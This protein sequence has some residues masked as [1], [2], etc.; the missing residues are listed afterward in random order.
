MQSIPLPRRVEREIDAELRFHLESRVEDLIAAGH[1]AE[2]ARQIAAAEYGNIDASRRELAE[3]DRRI[4]ARSR[5][6]DR[7]DGIRHDI[8]YAARSLWRQPGFTIGVGLTLAIA[9]GANAAVFTLIDPLLFRP[10][11]GVHDPS[12]VVRLYVNSPNSPRAVNGRAI[13]PYVSY[14]EFEAIR[15][16]SKGLA[17]IAAHRQFDSSLVNRG[18]DSAFVNVSYVTADFLSILGVRATRGRFFIAIE[19]DVDVPANVCVVSEA[20]AHRMFIDVERA[21][22]QP[23]LVR[24]KPCTVIGVAGGGFRGISTSATD[25]WAPFSGQPRFGVGKV[26][27]YRTADT[28][29]P[30]IARLEPGAD[31]L[32][33]AT[34]ASVGLVRAASQPRSSDEGRSVVLG[35]LIEGRGPLATPQV[36]AIGTRLAVVVA[37]ILVIA[38]ANVGNLYL[39]RAIRRRR[40]T[41]MRLAL[42]ISRGRL[43]RQS[44]IEG[45]LLA[46][47]CGLAA[48]FVAAWGGGVLRT[49]LLPRIHWIGAPLDTR[50][51]AFSVVT[52]LLA[53]LLAAIVPATV[54]NQ[55]LI[56]ESLKLGL[57][58]A[59]ADGSRV[60]ATLLAIQAALSLVLVVG[61]ALFVQS[62]RNVQAIDFGIDTDHVVS[63]SVFFLDGKAHREVETLIP[64]VVQNLPTMAGVRGV[65][66]ATG[67]PLVAWSSGVPLFESGRASEITSE[68]HRTDFIGVAAGY[69]EVVGTP[70]VA[71][72]TFLASDRRDAPPVAVVSNSLAKTLWPNE[73]AIGKCLIP[74]ERRNPCYTIVGV[75]RDVHEFRLMETPELHFYLPIDQVP[76]GHAPLAIFVNADAG[77]LDAVT[78]SLTQTLTGTFPGGQVR[79]R[80][81]AT[82]LAPQLRPWRLGAQL[83]GALG[84][85]SLLVASVGVYSVV[86]FTVQQR[87]HEIG[88]R[89]TLGATAGDIIRHVVG[90][91][92][93]V[94]AV[95]VVVGVAVT[96][97]GGRFIASLLYGISPRDVPAIAVSASA[98]LLV[99]AV[100]SLAPACRAMR[101]DPATILR[102]E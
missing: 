57:R 73:S 62:L 69:F 45:F 96:L 75:A 38:C 79:V 54:A 92:S 41:A 80:S 91:S 93:L 50:V 85:L 78:M 99:G 67:G 14:P 76:R 71:G 31:A 23:L 21:I 10:P 28:Y 37:I 82:A 18:D 34:R 101:V 56:V 4:A 89:V 30:L 63:A 97:I 25:V 39:A 87:M 40:E 52:V 65:T 35:P 32:S 27:W 5:W 59:G 100:A 90:R 1:T 98:L 24:K 42:G 70:I 66:Y 94:V 74:D 9:V 48:L 46:L 19:D 86:S 13:G 33:L 84:V 83:F 26:P 29:I 72:R 11:A 61:A 20:F 55:P 7:F 43:I 22:G 2:S 95:G 8:V 51:L 53:S 49:T 12:R 102:E 88:V 36:V 77:R 81:A 16:A 3:L 44:V 58:G 6:T 17:G 47:L 60:R 68:G 64:Q 15:A